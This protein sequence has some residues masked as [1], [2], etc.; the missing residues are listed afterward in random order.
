[1]HRNAVWRR[2]NKLRK[3]LSEA[4]EYGMNSS[5]RKAAWLLL[6]MAAGAAPIPSGAQQNATNAVP[7]GASPEVR[8]AGSVGAGPRR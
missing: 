7:P 8:L 4:E 5:R 6:L 2:V 1:M 3:R